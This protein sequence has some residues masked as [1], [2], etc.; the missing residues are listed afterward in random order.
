MNKGN[1]AKTQGSVPGVSSTLPCPIITVPAC[2]RKNTDA[3]VERRYER[4]FLSLCVCDSS[5]GTV[6]GLWLQV[7]H[8]DTASEGSGARR[9]CLAVR[10]GL[11]ELLLVVLLQLALSLLPLV[12][13]EYSGS[14]ACD[15]HGEDS[16]ED[17]ADYCR[18]LLFF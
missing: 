18:F 4:L 3:K 13:P 1:W 5:C 2:T 11:G 17:T 8:H 10:V 14:Q 12:H 6:A 9:Q 16:C 7:L 15:D